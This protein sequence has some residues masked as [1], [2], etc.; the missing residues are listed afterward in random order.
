MVGLVR[1][2]RLEAVLVDRVRKIAR[3]IADLGEIDAVDD[4][5]I[6]EATML[7]DARL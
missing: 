6:E 7:R 2:G 5:H 1:L 3:T 4:A